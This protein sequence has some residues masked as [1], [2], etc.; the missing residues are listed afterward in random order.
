MASTFTYDMTRSALLDTMVP[1]AIV[2][3]IGGA[4]AGAMA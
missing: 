1:T 3:F 2:P 4:F